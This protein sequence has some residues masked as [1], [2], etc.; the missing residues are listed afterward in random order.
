MFAC[1]WFPKVSVLGVTWWEF[2]HLNPKIVSL[3]LEANKEKQKQELQKI[4]AFFHLEGQYM[5]DALMCTV[6]NMFSGK[7]AKKYQYP[8]K[9]YDIE[10]QSEELSEEE[11]QKQ[12]ELFITK[13]QI[14][15]NNYEINN[16]DS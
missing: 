16:K 14:M 4:N 7:S 5:A 8:K 1:E 3:M 9:P 11:I 2:W 6:G 15:K 10:K 12:R 13:L